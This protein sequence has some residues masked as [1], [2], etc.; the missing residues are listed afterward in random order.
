MGGPRHPL[1]DIKKTLAA[2]DY[3]MCRRMPETMEIADASFVRVFASKAL[4]FAEM[5]FGEI[6]NRDGRVANP[7]KT[8]S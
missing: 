7:P 1:D 4:P 8:G 6:V 3:L 5:L 2:G